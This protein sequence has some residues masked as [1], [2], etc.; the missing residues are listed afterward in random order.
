MQFR[1]TVIVEKLSFLCIGHL[2]MTANIWFL[3]LI[4]LYLL[5]E[6]FMV[7]KRGIANHFKQ[8]QVVKRRGNYFCSGLNVNLEVNGFHITDTDNSRSYLVPVELQ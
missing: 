7:K 8:E 3:K 1:K 4:T 5:T 2:Q 6:I